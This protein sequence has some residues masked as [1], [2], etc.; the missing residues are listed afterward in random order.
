MYDLD[1]DVECIEERPGQGSDA[2]INNNNNSNNSNNNNV[3]G[4]QNEET[5]VESILFI[6]LINHSFHLMCISNSPCPICLEPANN[7]TMP[8]S[9]IHQFCFV[10]FSSLQFIN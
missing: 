1:K 9:C 4:Q 6:S 2:I 3:P 7:P 8:D 10:S 5:K